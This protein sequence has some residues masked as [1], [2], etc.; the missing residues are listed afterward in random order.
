MSLFV[1]TIRR[2]APVTSRLGWTRSMSNKSSLTVNFITEEG[3]RFTVK[4][5]EGESI[6]RIAHNN[7]IDLEGACDC[8]LACSTCHVVLPKEYYDKL[9]EPSDEENDMLDL[10]FGL[11]DTS[12]LGCQ[13]VMRP[14]LDGITCKIPSGTRNLV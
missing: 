7:Y 13:I 9:E 4:A 2:V 11:T 5:P 6:M 8:S 10:A 12:R 14:E 1:S 3:E